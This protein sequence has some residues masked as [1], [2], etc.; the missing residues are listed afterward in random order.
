MEGTN[1]YQGVIKAIKNR[2]GQV[3]IEVMA[4]KSKKGKRDY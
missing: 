1:N 4:K 2:I 3:E